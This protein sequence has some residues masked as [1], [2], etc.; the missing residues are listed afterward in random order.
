[1]K[2][3]VRVVC[4]MLAAGIAV[5]AS[6]ALELEDLAALGLEADAIVPIEIKLAAA[7]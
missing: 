2:N 1:M 4:C 6:A 5:L 3:L 7:K